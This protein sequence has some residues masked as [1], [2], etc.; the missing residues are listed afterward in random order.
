[1]NCLIYLRVSTKEQ[2]EGGYSIPVPGA[3]GFEPATV[4]REPYSLLA[5][6]RGHPGFPSEI[7]LSLRMIKGE[8]FPLKEPP[9]SNPA[10][11]IFQKGRVGC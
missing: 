9:C 4:A 3:S 6:Q 5:P 8:Y 10:I 7:S 11:Q 1:M 2:A